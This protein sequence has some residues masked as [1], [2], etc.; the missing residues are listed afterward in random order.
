[1]KNQWSKNLLEMLVSR[2]ARMHYGLPDTLFAL[3]GNVILADFRAARETAAAINRIRRSAGQAE[4][5][6]SA[7]DVNAAGLLHEMMHHLIGVYRDTVDPDIFARALRELEIDLGVPAVEATLE[8]FVEAFPSQAVRDGEISPPYYLEGSTGGMANRQVV[9]EEILLL[10]LANA[11]PALESLRDM[12]ADTELVQG[13]AY[14]ALISRLQ[15]FFKGRPG[16]ESGGPTLVELLREP[17][18]ASP[19]S[20]QGQLEFIRGRWGV[21][22]ENLVVRLLGGLDFLS[23]E[24]RPVFPPGPGPSVAPT[25]G[26]WTDEEFEAF[27]ADLEWMPRV[28]LIA[29]NAYVWLNQ[30]AREYDKD[31]C[32]FDQIPDEALDRLHSQGITG[33]WLIGLWE[34]S[35]ASETIKRWMGDQDAVASA[36]SL[37]DYTVATDL[38]GEAAFDDLKARAWE[39]GI[40]MTTDMVPNHVG[41]D[42]RWVIEHPDW[43]IGLPDCPYP[44]YRFTGEDLCTDERVGIYLEDGYWD[45]SDAAVVFK[46]VDHWT[47]EV[48]YIYHGNDGTSMPWNDTAQLDYR[49]P[50]VREAVIKTIFHVARLSPIIRFDAAMTLTRKNFQRLW[51]PEPGTGG[52]IPSRSGFGISRADF[53]HMMPEEFWREVV[54]RVAVET[55]DTLL[56]A[57]AFWMLEGYFVRTLG[58]HRV[59]NSAF[60]NMLRDEANDEYRKLIRNTLEYDPRILSRYVNFMS[61]PDEETAE[62]QFGRGDKYFGVCTLMATLPGLPMFGHGQI[63]GYRE[64]YGMEFRTPRKDEV[65]DE[66]LLL[67]HDVQI[68]PLLRRRR[69]FSGVENFRLY[70]L[71]TGDGAVDEN[72]FAYSNEFDGERSLVIYHNTFGDTSGWIDN[73]S[74]MLEPWRDGDHAPVLYRLGGSLGLTDSRQ[75]FV[76]FR[77]LVSG[78]EYIRPSREI[79][80]QGLFVQLNAYE[81]H[82]FWQFREVIEGDGVS[83]MQ[84]VEYLQGRGV[85]D[86]DVARRQLGFASVLGPW[87]KVLDVLAETSGLPE[88]LEDALLTFVV[89]ARRLAGTEGPAAPAVF[90]ALARIES[91]ASLV[92]DDKD[93]GTTAWRPLVLA[94]WAAAGVLHDIVGESESTAGDQWAEW[95]MGLSLAEVIRDNGGDAEVGETSDAAVSLL[96]QIE[97]WPLRLLEDQSDQ[98]VLEGLLA[99]PAFRDFLGVNTWDDHQWFQQEALEEAIRWMNIAA[100][101]WADDHVGGGD[102]VLIEG[103]RFLL[104]LA[105]AGEASGYRVDR[106]LDGLVARGEGTL[107]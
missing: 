13:S 105:A 47:G 46:R 58:M 12:F 3:D 107:Q 75:A 66:G 33:L 54:D 103:E 55:P 25:Y 92:K 44:E 16:L 86:V 73:A 57:E 21:W 63:E 19:D 80:E 6:V 39:R 30:L 51:F 53:E 40:R 38:G 91:V 32:R 95:L 78:L 35:R 77:D 93:D 42:G 100:R 45:R 70:D 59:Y 41:I 96:L 56:L 94:S 8:A 29:K 23:E 36:Y 90:H 71:R 28:V 20:L 37:Y 5:C 1:M 34:R 98:V 81:L 89:A 102:N 49:K 7:S 48:R 11:N 52:D 97:D 61:N 79:R 60:M 27:S 87:R 88:A 4:L 17:V 82:V 68:F 43:F 14:S 76:V 83:W 99:I 62:E 9:L 72:V 74:P 84:V 67:R 104:A 31:I 106:L 101:R 2:R 18:A 26:D 24:H 50:E 69:L 22:I 65:P 10:W 85:D 64:K 15:T